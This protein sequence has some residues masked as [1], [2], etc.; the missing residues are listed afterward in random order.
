MTEPKDKMTPPPLCI[1]CGDKIK[2]LPDSKDTEGKIL[3]WDEDRGEYRFA[4]HPDRIKWSGGIV[5]TVNTQMDS[6]FEG[7][8][9]LIAVCDSCI[10][11]SLNCG[12][13]KLKGNYIDDSDIDERAKKYRRNTN[14]NKLT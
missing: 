6:K 1:C 14:L 2:P 3:M 8:I 13:L 7:D 9:Y 10:E 12:R 4:S 11:K 5:D